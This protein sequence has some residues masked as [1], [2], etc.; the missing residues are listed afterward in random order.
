MALT[1]IMVRLLRA[2]QAYAEMENTERARRFA[3][4]KRERVWAESTR[5][6]RSVFFDRS[7][8]VWIR[9]EEK[10]SWPAIARTI[11]VGVGT[12]SK[13]VRGNGGGDL[14]SSLGN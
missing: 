8:V 11:G 3:A 12:G 5:A 2:I 10:L 1:C 14:R 7:E 13:S 6:D 4:A 9:N